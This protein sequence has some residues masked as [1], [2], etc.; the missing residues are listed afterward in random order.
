MTTMYEFEKAYIAREA[1]HGASAI[2]VGIEDINLLIALDT[3]VDGGQLV[4]QPTFNQA[5]IRDCLY[6]LNPERNNPPIQI[7]SDWVVPQYVS[8][9]ERLKRPV[10]L[11]TGTT[12]SISCNQEI[13]DMNLRITETNYWAKR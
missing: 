12:K 3:G 6:F 9:E 11:K 13:D 4:G 1:K 8:P 2:K 7:T 10:E 5:M